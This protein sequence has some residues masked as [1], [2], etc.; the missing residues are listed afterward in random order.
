MGPDLSCV[1]IGTGEQEVPMDSCRKRGETVEGF[2]NS[3]EP[4]KIKAKTT[5]KT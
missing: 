4:R 5:V 3:K 1:I 2:E